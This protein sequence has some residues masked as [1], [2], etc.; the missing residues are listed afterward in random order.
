[1]SVR[2]LVLAISLQG[3]RILA[4]FVGGGTALRQRCMPVLTFFPHPGGPVQGV[5]FQACELPVDPTF[6]ECH[7][8]ASSSDCASP[9]S[10]NCLKNTRVSSCSAASRA[11]ADGIYS[12]NLGIA[13]ALFHWI[14]VPSLFFR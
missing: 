14:M 7:D 2:R 3:C 4:C 8:L 5:P 12:G 11:T 6:F 13:V 1:M 10:L 9:C